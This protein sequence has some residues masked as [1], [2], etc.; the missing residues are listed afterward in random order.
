MNYKINNSNS[1]FK[2]NK[3][4]EK[5]VSN[6]ITNTSEFKPTIIPNSFQNMNHVITNNQDLKDFKLNN[7]RITKIINDDLAKLIDNN[8]CVYCLKRVIKP[9]KLTCD[10]ELCLSCAEEIIS[11]YKFIHIP[12]LEVKYIKCPKSKTKSEIINNDLNNMLRINWCPSHPQEE[13]EQKFSNEQKIVE[14]K[15]QLCEICPNS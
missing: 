7:L 1:N 8:H 12:N 15:L 4:L 10:H 5:K 6:I 9:I 11:L 14:R 3:E 2:V 13:T